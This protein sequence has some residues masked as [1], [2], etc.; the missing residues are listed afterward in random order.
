ML[1][2]S[3]SVENYGVRGAKDVLSFK[4]TFDGAMRSC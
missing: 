4:M 1:I 3:S 2:F